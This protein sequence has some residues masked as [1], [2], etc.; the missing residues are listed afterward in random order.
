MFYETDGFGKSLTMGNPH[1][2]RNG[3]STEQP[4]QPLFFLSLQEHEPLPLRK[5]LTAN[6]TRA[7]TTNN[8]MAVAQFMR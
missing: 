4:A 5:A 3:Q 1:H 2:F 6:P 8:T 7:A